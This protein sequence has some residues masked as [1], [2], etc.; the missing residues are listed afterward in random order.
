MLD[1]FK[2]ISQGKF[3]I[4]CTGVIVESKNKVMVIRMS[5]SIE[6]IPFA[7]PPPRKNQRDYLVGFL[8]KSKLHLQVDMEPIMKRIILKN[9]KDVQRINFVLFKGK[10]KKTSQGIGWKSVNDDN[11]ISVLV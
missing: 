1:F 2:N 3:V 8:N 6:S 10:I 11:L 4:K 9:G 7:I 5:K